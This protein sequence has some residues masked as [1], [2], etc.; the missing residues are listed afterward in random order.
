VRRDGIALIT[1]LAILVVVGVLAFGT[2]FTTQIEQWTARNDSTSTQANYVAQAGLQKYKTILFQNYRWVEQGSTSSPS[3]G[4]TVCRNSLANGIDFDRDGTLTPFTGGTMGPFTESV[5]D[6]SGRVIGQYRVTITKATNNPQIYTVTSVGTSA[7]ARSTVQ[8]VFQIA[9]TGYLDNAIFAGQGQANK[10]INGGAT[11]RGGIYIVGDPSNPSQK[12]IES[13]GNF[14]LLNHYNMSDYSAVSNR[15]DPANQVANDLC[16]SLRVQYG[17]VEVGGSTLIGEPTNKVKGVYVGNGASDVSGNASDVCTRTKGI[18]TEQGPAPFDIANAPGFPTLGSRGECSIAGNPT[19]TWR[20]CIQNQSSTP[21]SGLRIVR[22]AG[23]TNLFWPTLSPNPLVPPAACL[24]FLNTSSLTFNTQ[25]V[26]C[27]YTLPDGRKGGFV[28]NG[29]SSPARFTVYGSV[30]F[31]GFNLT[32]SKAIDYTA[33]SWVSA[34]GSYTQVNTASLTV[35]KNSTGSGGTLDLDSNLLPKTSDGFFPQHVLGLVVEG[36][37]Y[38][39]G[40]YVMAPLYSGGTFR[41]VKDNV[42]FGSVVANMFCTTSA[43]NQSSCAAGQKSEVVYINTG[44]NKPSIMRQVERSTI[45]VFKILSYER[46]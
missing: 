43:G 9:N 42:L 44:A 38:Q 20:D 36:D 15:V 40:Q 27:S 24:T 33:R 22:V 39:R 34:N 12:V 35:M 23:V 13:N 5:T 16:A 41:I 14:S 45:P 17:K 18:C 21:G 11:I 19:P 2:F 28:Y 26:D 25:N 29:S 30:D 32:F 7:G 3:G 4:S 31:E 8:A 1:T 37:V 46:R 10:F 6:T